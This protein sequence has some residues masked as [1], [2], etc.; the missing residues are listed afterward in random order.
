MQ[1]ALL[2]EIACKSMIGLTKKIH[3]KISKF[4]DGKVNNVSK[5]FKS[6]CSLVCVLISDAKIRR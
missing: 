3:E 6:N 1:H 2:M 5:N 4:K